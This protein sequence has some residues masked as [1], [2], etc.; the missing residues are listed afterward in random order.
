MSKKYKLV[1]AAIVSAAVLLTQ[2]QAARLVQL[3]Q[4]EPRIAELI[5]RAQHKD[6]QGNVHT[7]YVQTVD[8]LPVYGQQVI[9]HQYAARTQDEAFPLARWTGTWVEGIEEDLAKAQALRSMDPKAALA[10]FK[11]A[12]SAEQSQPVVFENDVV[13]EVIYIDDENVA[14]RAL[15]M[16]FFTDS[17]EGGNPSWPHYI[18]DAATWEVLKSW[19]GLTTQAVGTGPGGNGKT[20]YYEY[21]VTRPYMPFEVEVIGGKTCIM[22]SSDV[23]AIHMQSRMIGNPA[24]YQ[25]ACDA[26]KGVYRQDTDAVN[27]AHSPINDAYSFGGVVVD[28]YEDWYDQKPLPFGLV[29]R[30]HYGRD[31]VNAF[32]NG[33][34]MT[35]GDGNVD[36]YPLTTLDVTSHEIAHG[37]T[38]FASNLEYEGEAGGLNES[39]SDMAAKA[40]EFYLFGNHDWL[41]GG[42]V[43]KKKG[44][45]FRYMDEPTKDGVS[46]N[47]AQDFTAKMDPH[48]S[49]GVYNK[50]FYTLATTPG[51]TTQ[52]AFDVMYTANL[53]YWTPTSNFATAGWGAIVSAYILGYSYTDVINAL[54]AV[55]VKCSVAT[56]SCRT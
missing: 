36:Y 4:G 13:E 22:Q 56:Q 10:H 43:A 38:Q 8:G 31:Y 2:A 46:I 6:K 41:I 16:A 1:G 35:F 30:V 25:Y 51:W 9:D 3:P 23:N 45:A 15:S 17:V 7:R 42:T 28:M 48:L 19:E 20:G 55:G 24:V 40:A 12:F 18:V 5:E 44:T 21:G 32:W 54:S 52:K 34:V 26:R 27:G 37:V 50:A 29:L 33:T 49:S 14:R 47:T 39:F 11:T 53:G